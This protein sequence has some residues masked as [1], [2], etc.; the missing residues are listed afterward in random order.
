M[1][2][3]VLRA[4]LCLA[5]IAALTPAARAEFKLHYPVIDYRELEFEHNGAVSFDKRDSGLNNGQSYVNEI[6]YGVFPWWKPGIEGEWEA[7]PGENLRFEATTFENYFQL[8]PQGKYWLDLGFFAEYSHAASRADADS[9]TFG[10]LVQKEQDFLG[11]DLLHTANVLFSKEVGRNRSDATPVLLAWQTR[12]RLDPRFEPGLEYYGQLNPIESREATGNPQ[13]RLGPVLVGLFNFYRYG[14]VRY[15]L[16]YLFGLNRT[17]EQGA[18]RWRL[19][20]E[21]P[22]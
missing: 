11:L 17:T 20:Y 21:K 16:G 13:H 12:L 3:L 5:A 19:E 4:A 22:F 9:F 2:R 6:E 14:K 7:A 15:E 8:A 18:V 10:P 1:T